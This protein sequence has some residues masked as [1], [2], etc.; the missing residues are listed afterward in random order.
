MSL[1]TA[2]VV[3]SSHFFAGIFF[4]FLK[5]CPPPNLKGFQGQIWI[6]VKILGEYLSRFSAFLHIICSDF[7]LKL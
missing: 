4:I 7:R 5:Q 3:T 2:I 6:S 1:L